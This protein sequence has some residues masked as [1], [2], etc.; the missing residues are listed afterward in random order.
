MSAFDVYGGLAMFGSLESSCCRILASCD[1]PGHGRTKGVTTLDVAV[2]A[3][4]CQEDT[5]NGM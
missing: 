4:A 2:L 3:A 5:F 1:V